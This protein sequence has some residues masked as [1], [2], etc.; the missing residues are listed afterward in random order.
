MYMY[1]MYH[2]EN[3]DYL[4]RQFPG[5]PSFPSIPGLP[6][7]PSQPGFP[8]APGFP[9]QPGF[10][11]APGS[12]GQ[13]G[14]PPSSQ[15]P[16]APPPSFIPLQQSA[17]TFAVDPGAISFC[18]FRNTFIWLNNGAS[19]WYYPIFVGPRSVAGFRWNGRFWTVFGIDTRQINSFTCF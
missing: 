8:G 3:Q 4:I 13:P 15:A 1:P 12:P 14:S 2:Y 17:S 16:T 19:F 9:G 18:L 7:L 6:G 11:G 10:P 5:L